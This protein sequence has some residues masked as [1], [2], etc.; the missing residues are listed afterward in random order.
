[1]RPCSKLVLILL[2]NPE[3]NK[4]FVLIGH[5]W[6]PDFDHKR[7]DFIGINIEIIRFPTHI[8]LLGPGPGISS[9]LPEFFIKATGRINLVDYPSMLPGLTYYD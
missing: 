4:G 3:Y 7:I 8:E 5:F 1:M 2:W 9:T 6:H